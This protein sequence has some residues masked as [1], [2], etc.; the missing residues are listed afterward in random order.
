MKLETYLKAGIVSGIV[1][2]ACTIVFG[3]LPD[4]A[5]RYD[6]YFRQNGVPTISEGEVKAKYLESDEY[7]SFSERF[8]DHNVEFWY[9]NNESRF[10]AVAYNPETK[11]ALILNMRYDTWSDQMNK[12]VQ[13]STTKLVSGNRYNAD[14]LMVIPFIKST[15]CLE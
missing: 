11:N 8:P 10:G 3:I 13:C 4:F 12:D 6:N 7:K 5:N 9:G 15:E 2:V 1:L 14:G